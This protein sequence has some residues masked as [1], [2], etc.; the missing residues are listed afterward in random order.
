[1]MLFRL[2]RFQ[3]CSSWENHLCMLKAMRKTIRSRSLIK[4]NQVYVHA[5]SSFYLAKHD[6]AVISSELLDLM[7]SHC[8]NAVD[9]SHCLIFCHLHMRN[10]WIQTGMDW[11]IE[12][13]THVGMGKSC[14]SHLTHL[15]NNCSSFL[16]E[17]TKTS[18]AAGG[19]LPSCWLFFSPGFGTT[20]QSSRSQSTRSNASPGSQH[21]MFPCHHSEAKDNESLLSFIHN[22]W[23]NHTQRWKV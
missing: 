14:G 15:P 10:P 5:C 21:L 2:C 4:F 1:M 23:S 17:T 9:R 12:A 22:I 20:W 16:F 8:A 6:P 18:V 19:R 3:T 7:A 11:G 13:Q